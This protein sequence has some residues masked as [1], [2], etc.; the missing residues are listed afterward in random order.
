MKLYTIKV[1]NEE[2]VAAR[3]ADDR[4][5]LLKDLGYEFSD[6]N[7]LIERITDEDK[8]Q[9]GEI[10]SDHKRLAV[11]TSYDLSE[12]RLCAPIPV[13]RQDIICLGVNYEE[14]ILE[15]GNAEEY[16]KKEATVY[17]SKRVN[18]A[19]GPEDE[20]PNYAFVDSL[21]YEAELG[22][23]I[24]KA[25]NHYDSKSGT[26]CIFGYTVINDVSARNL[27][28]RHK[29]WYVGKSLDGYVP[30]GPCIVTAD[31]IEDIQNLDI[32][33]RVN[34]EIRQHSNTS[35]MI[36][37]VSGAVEEL[38]RGITLKAG[39]I[40]STGTPGGVGFAMKPPAC[41]KAGDVVECEVEK[42]GVL[43]N[44]VAE[45]AETPKI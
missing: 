24:G 28:F 32:V 25:V 43:R 3:G 20:I 6:M 23:I 19:S 31:E 44:K 42:I 33:C 4:I 36:Q 35:L 13:P 10:L 40:I 29:Q 2:A 45:V 18:R 30:M 1:G 22:V 7:E 34:G 41:L 8:K 12:V 26:D 14:H 9:L 15:S 37:T 21:D 27:Q 11:L 39:T 38:S 16:L 17:F 5:Y